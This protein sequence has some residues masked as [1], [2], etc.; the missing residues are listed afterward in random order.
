VFLKILIGLSG[1]RYGPVRGFSYDKDA[2]K[3][4][5]IVVNFRI[6]GM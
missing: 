4:S 2:L 6:I 1:L 3:D 5:I